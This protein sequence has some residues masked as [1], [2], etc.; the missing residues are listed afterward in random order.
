MTRNGKER[1]VCSYVFFL[2]KK[3]SGKA[4]EPGPDCTDWAMPFHVRQVV[5]ASLP[6]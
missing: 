2:I 1:R 6:Q 5:G 3:N 4:A